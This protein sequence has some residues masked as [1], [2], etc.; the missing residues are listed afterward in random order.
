MQAIFLEHMFSDII[1]EVF[2]SITESGEYDDFTVVV[3]ERML[4]FVVDIGKQLLQFGIMFRRHDGNH[5]DKFRNG[6]AIGIEI[7]FPRFVIQ[8]V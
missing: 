4:D 2:R 5:L 6:F 7:P 1:V 3:V 8:I